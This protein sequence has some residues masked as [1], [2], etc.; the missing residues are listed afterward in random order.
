MDP[1]KQLAYGRIAVGAASY[2]T[3]RLA[4]GAFGLRAADN[5]QAPYLA[6]L[7][8]ARDAI[9]G[10]GAL[11]SEGSA[12]TGWI[13][14]GIAADVADAAAAL[15]SRKESALAP[16]QGLFLTGIALVGAAVGFKALRDA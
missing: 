5:P 13:K 11:L 2:A 6:R 9:L 16:R 14:A 15:L 4:G 12:R 7:F 10:A 3:P 1:A 8:G